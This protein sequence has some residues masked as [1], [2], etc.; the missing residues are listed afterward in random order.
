MLKKLL[1]IVTGV[2][3][4]VSALAAGG[5]GSPAPLFVSVT[6]SPNVPVIAVSNNVTIQGVSFLTPSGSGTVAIYDNISTNA[7]YLGTNYV[8]S[9][10]VSRASYATNTVTSYVGYNGY[11][12]YYTNTGYW[13]YNVTNAAATNVLTPQGVFPVIS[14]VVSTYN[15]PVAANLGA[16][17]VATTNTT[18]LIYYTPNR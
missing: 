15:T 10:Y 16:V 3:I 18:A 4:G 6:L 5:T 9:A 17:F 11:T 14:G 7:P 2:S 8:T 12:N 13:T 1:S